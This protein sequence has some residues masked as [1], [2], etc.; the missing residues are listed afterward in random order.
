MI[1]RAVPS[2]MILAFNNVPSKQCAFC[3]FKYIFSSAGGQLSTLESTSE[4]SV[5]ALLCYERY[6][7]Y[8][9]FLPTQVNVEKK[10]NRKQLGFESD[11]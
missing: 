3:C 11:S 5:K 9:F 2:V 1:C 8:I 7:N 4:E 10:K 6:A